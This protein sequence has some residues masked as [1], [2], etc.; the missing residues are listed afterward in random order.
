PPAV[1]AATGAMLRPFSTCF[2][3]LQVHLETFQRLLRHFV[4]A[5]PYA[6]ENAHVFREGRLQ[7]RQR[8]GAPA[9]FLFVV[10]VGLELRDAAHLAPCRSVPPRGRF[11]FG[12]IFFPSANPRRP[13]ARSPPPSPIAPAPGSNPGWSSARRP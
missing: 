10:A 3:G 5:V 4:Q 12:Q 8:A 7:I 13:P 11:C 9:Q 1:R 2:D 6:V